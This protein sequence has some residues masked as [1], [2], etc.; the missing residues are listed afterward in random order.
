MT[1][2]I[3]KRLDLIV[4]ML[5]VL[6]NQV[7]SQTNYPNSFLNGLTDAAL[8]EGFDNFRQDFQRVFQPQKKLLAEVV[9]ALEAIKTDSDG[10]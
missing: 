4:A 9:K 8:E 6:V 1:Q 3:E 10:Q 2:S 5:F 7:E